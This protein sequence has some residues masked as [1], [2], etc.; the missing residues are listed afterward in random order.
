MAN[1]TRPD[2]VD[3]PDVEAGEFF[4][5]IQHDHNSYLLNEL[6]THGPVHLSFILLFFFSLGSYMSTCKV[7]VEHWNGYTF[8]NLLFLKLFACV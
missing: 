1:S 4:E 2:N 6:I 3:K 7:A 8:L 5:R